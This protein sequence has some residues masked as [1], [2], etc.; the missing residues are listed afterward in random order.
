MWPRRKQQLAVTRSM[1]SQAQL[2]A[3]LTKFMSNAAARRRCTVSHFVFVVPRPK[4][5]SGGWRLAACATLYA[6]TVPAAANATLDA[7]AVAA[8][9]DA[10]SASTTCSSFCCLPDCR[11]TADASYDTVYCGASGNMFSIQYRSVTHC[12]KNHRRSV[13]SIAHFLPTLCIFS[14][15]FTLCLSKTYRI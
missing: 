11:A 13:V 12:F 1:T 3:S 8:A 15:S 14:R 7:N 9:T 5:R 2:S 6:N 4:K 10:C